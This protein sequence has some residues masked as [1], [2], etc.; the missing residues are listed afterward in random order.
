[1]ILSELNLVRYF[2]PDDRPNVKTTDLSMRRQVSLFFV[3]FIGVTMLTSVHNYM[4]MLGVSKTQG[5][6]VRKPFIPVVE[7]IKKAKIPERSKVYIVAQH[8]VGFEYFV[9]RYE[10]AGKKFGQVPWSMGTPFGDT[11]VWTDPT[12][13]KEKWS[14]ALQEFD[15]V[16]LYKTTEDFNSEFGS[17]FETGVVETDAVYRIV[18]DG[19]RVTLSKIG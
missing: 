15:Y 9:L 7:A 3:A 17:L 2:H 13:D 8:T 4:M 1:L 11:D 5:S 18:N 14:N 10:M 6:E 19:S 12:W 16:V